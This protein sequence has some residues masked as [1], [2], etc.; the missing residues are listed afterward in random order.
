MNSTISRRALGGLTVGAALGT[1][2]LAR[3]QA[4]ELIIVSFAGQLQEPHQW[5]A[6]R[7][8]QRHPGLRIRLV[9]SEAQDIVAQIKAAQ[10]QSP[11]DAMPNGEPPH[12]TAQAEGYIQRLRPDRVPNAA[13]V[14]PEFMAKSGG[15]GVPASYSL[16]GLAYNTRVVRREPTSWQDLWHADYRGKVAI[17]RASSNL[18][19]AVLAII[20]KVFGGSE[21]NLAPAWEK[22]AALRPMV[23]RSPTALIQLL[24]REEIGVAPIWNNDAAGAAARGLPI[25]FVQPAP[26]PVSLISFMS[27]ITNTRHPDLVQEWMNDILSA[28]YQQHAANA[29]YFFGPTVRGVAVPEAAR[30]YTPSTPAEVAALQSVDWAR[31]APARGRILE[32][33]DRTFA[34]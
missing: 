21:D 31:I 4:R 1:P 34:G 25:R 20:A 6:R 23:G 16:V 15:F 10:G 3:A 29:P 14:I 22:L 27:E 2:R 8:E 18:G 9:P 30:G 5:L 24:E 19:L 28:E 32:Q 17:P 26:G 7:M 12:L 33:F 11:Y 13:N